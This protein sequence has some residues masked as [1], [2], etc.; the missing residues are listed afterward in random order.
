MAEEK[1]ADHR[2]ADGGFLSRKLVFAT[3]TSILIVV[4]SLVVP[5][6]AL[7]TVIEGLTFV[8]A[9]YVGGNAATRFIQTRGQAPAP[10]SGAPKKLVSK[11][12]NEDDPDA[13]PGATPGDPGVGH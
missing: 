6:V 5:G 3:F 11:K 13:W 9:I 2:A 7:S 10:A 1:S 4:A 8:C 12:E